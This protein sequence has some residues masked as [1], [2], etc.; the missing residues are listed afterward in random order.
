MSLSPQIRSKTPTIDVYV[1]LAQYPVLSD[2]IRVKMREEMFRRGIISQSEFEKEVK[3]LAI[4]SQ[5]REGLL[6]PYGQEDEITWQKRLNAIRDMHTDAIFGNN[7]GPALLDQVIQS[8]LVDQHHT[9]QAV[10]LTFNPEIAP[11][12]LLFHQGRMYEKL[13]PPEVDAVQH[14]LEEVKV[15]LIK[16]LISDHLKYIGLAKHIFSI[17]DLHWVY[18]RMVGAGKIGGKAGGMLLAWKILQHQTDVGAD[19][20]QHISIPETYFIGSEMIYTFLYF[21]KFEH[22]VNQKYLP[23]SERRRQFPE[24]MNEFMKG[25]LPEHHLKQLRDLLSRLGKRPFIVRS[26]SLLEDNLSMPFIDV[27][28]SVFCFNQGTDD[29]NFA[30]LLDALRKIYAVSFNPKAIEQREAHGLLDYDERMAIMIQPLVGHQ[31]GRFFFPVVMGHGISKKTPFGHKK[32][33]E[34]GLLQL[35]VGFDERFDSTKEEHNA[36]KVA[37]RTPRLREVNSSY[38]PGRSP[39]SDIK[40]IDLE[41]NTFRKMP[42]HDM[43]TP[44]FP[45]LSQ[46]AS[47][48]KQE[49][50]LPVPDAPPNGSYALTYDQL[51]QNPKFIKLMRSTLSR[52][53]KAYQVPVRIEFVLDFLPQPSGDFHYKLYL[54]QCHPQ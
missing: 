23:A 22:Y 18:E 25:Q 36:C 5:R 14:H 49:A 54:L 6:D 11:W 28:Q 39:Q 3:A 15:V 52:L 9:S 7:L 32:R 20:S 41:A 45:Y 46:L 53:E 47:L 34:D 21:N 16:R 4:E 33:P 38:L 44:D 29:E 40:L 48:V 13:P 27:Y 31:Y 24:I 17:D 51:T 35:V 19:I 1:K 10:E 2:T 30:A 42:L 8:V 50:L 43:L 37:L 12:A 26:S